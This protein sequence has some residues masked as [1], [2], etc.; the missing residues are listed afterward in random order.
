MDWKM[1]VVVRT[2]ADVMVVPIVV[3]GIYLIVHGHLTPGGGFQGGA[4]IAS[5]TALLIVARGA[6]RD[7]KNDF[8]TMESTGLT[9]FFLLALLGIIMGFSLFYNSLAGTGGI[10][11]GTVSGINSGYINTG[12]TVPLMNIVVGMEVAAALSLILWM[13]AKRS[14]A[15]EVEE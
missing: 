10:F 1:S 5:A 15:L 13:M 7:N 6:M 11:G 8:S 4:V 2:V 12:G 3:F 9:C 14:G